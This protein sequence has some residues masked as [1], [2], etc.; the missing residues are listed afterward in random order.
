MGIMGQSAIIK[1]RKKVC[2]IIKNLDTQTALAK[3][4]GCTQPNISQKLQNGT[5]NLT[6]IMII[7][8]NYPEERE[9]ILRELI[10]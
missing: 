3:K 6:E 1:Q 10:Y 9:D 5:L 2:K 4:L 7:I 8:H